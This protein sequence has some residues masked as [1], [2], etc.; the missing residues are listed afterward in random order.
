VAD[1]LDGRVAI[2]TGAGRGIGEA[3]ARLFAAEG[4]AAVLVD[5]DG[6]PARA[7][8][9]AITVSGGR[10]AVVAGDASDP[11]VAEAAAA[12]AVERFGAIDVLVNNA[13]TTAD[14]AFADLDDDR[15][16]TVMAAQFGSALAMTRACVPVL[17][18]QATAELVEH[19]AVSHQR[20]I[21]ST[22]AGAYYTGNPGQANLAAAAGAVV[23]LTRTLAREL[24]GYGINVNAVAPGF[25]DTRLTA[26]EPAV[27]GLGVPEP[28]RQMTKAMTAL[29]RYG[30]AEDVARAHL[31]LA[32]ADAD[33]IT[34]VT[35]PVSG[36]LLGTAL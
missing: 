24:G 26:S 30:T 25:I 35:L 5:R 8:A 22:A 29:G 27:G 9:E 21:T 32:S 34:G 2:V 13:G 20:K 23:G 15:F 19:G 11:A 7:V 6:D 1:R 14:A 12:A 16:Q 31:F 10:A 18:E 33:F 28:V 17:R 4:A 3:T 36:G